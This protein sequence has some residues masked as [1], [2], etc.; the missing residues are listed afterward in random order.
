MRPIGPL[1][2]A[3]L[4][5]VACGSQ[6]TG[7][8]CSR[9]SDCGNGAVCDPAR[10]ICVGGSPTSPGVGT[11]A[12][13]DVVVASDT[14]VARPDVGGTGGCVDQYPTGTSR[15]TGAPCTDGSQCF[16]GFCMTTDIMAPLHPG[17]EVVGGMC[18]LLTCENDADCGSGARCLGT[19]HMDP[20]VPFRVCVASCDYAPCRCSYTCLAPVDT[21]GTSSV[22]LP[23]SLVAVMLCGNG[24]CDDWERADPT[25][26][27]AD[28]P[29]AS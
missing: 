23:D 17:I 12:T 25:R 18:S 19:S 10:L 6:G 22:C 15:A 3:A 5:G 20:S 21:G 26:C 1:V 9:S 11:V 4:L 27:P 16:T 13:K 24:R 7:T 29:G 14:A 28:C 8:P 2:A